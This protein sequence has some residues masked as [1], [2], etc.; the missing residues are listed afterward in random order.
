M[1]RGSV[2][3]GVGLLLLGNFHSFQ[4]LK[5]HPQILM[6]TGQNGSVGRP[7]LKETLALFLGTHQTTLLKISS[8]FLSS[9]R[10]STSAFS[11]ALHL[12][13]VLALYL[14]FR[15][16]TTCGTSSISSLTSR[17]TGQYC[18][19]SRLLNVSNV[20]TCQCFMSCAFLFLFWHFGIPK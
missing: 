14:S 17:S 12:K 11:L 20:F 2:N 15:P 4:T 19:F 5:N 18:S 6:N 13:L 7:P 3:D 8:S 16:V 1:V 9:F 10:Q